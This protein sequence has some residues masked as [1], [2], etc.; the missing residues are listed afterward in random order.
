MSWFS[1]DSAP[2]IL[3]AAIFVRTE[4]PECGAPIIVPGLRS[5][6]TCNA[7]RS[8][9]PVAKEFWSGLFFR[10][11]TAFPSQNAVSLS[12]A[13]AMTSEL[14]IY[15]RFAAEVPT[16]VACRAPLRTDVRPL[17]TD[18]PVPCS[19]CPVM[20]PSFGTPAWLRAEYPD[21]RHF[22][23]PMPLRLGPSITRPVS[24]A[25]PECGGKLRVTEATPRLVD[26]QYCEHA[27]FLPP[28]IWHALHPVA[29]RTPWWVAFAR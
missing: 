16:C 20:T 21:L 27:V 26:C 7:C 23:E 5:E 4:C 19:A 17:G 13:S 8:T 3:T 11:H 15:A 22:F 29:K 9:I 24:L 12:L 25:C 28:E 18:G 2:R 1:R 10:L 6:L 14:P